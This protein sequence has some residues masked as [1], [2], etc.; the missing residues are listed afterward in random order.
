MGKPTKISRCPRAQSTAALKAAKDSV[1]VKPT[2]V[3][4]RRQHHSKDP[5]EEK[6]QSS[7]VPVIDMK[8]PR[9]LPDKIV[10]AC[11]DWGC[12]RVSNH[13]IPT[14]LLSE[15]KGLA[16]YFLDLPTKI[17]KRNASWKPGQRLQYTLPY[18]VTP[19]FQSLRIDDMIFPG[20]L[21]DFCDRI[22]ASPHQRE[23]LVR[24]PQALYGA[25][26][27]ICEKIMQGYGLLGRG[28]KTSKDW[29]CDLQLNKY[30]FS[31]Q[32][33]GST[34]AIEHSD[35]G[36]FT[37]LQDDELVNGL[38]VMNKF[39]GEWVPVDPIPGTLVVLVG[40]TGMVWSNGRFCNVK[41]RVQCN[42]PM[43]RVSLATFV[44]V[45]RDK[46]VRTPEELIDS[47][48]PRLYKEFFY[49]EDYKH[50]RLSSSPTAEALEHFKVDSTTD[51]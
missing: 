1:S 43:T 46:I 26:I 49:Y 27:E 48:H 35:P 5:M 14:E 15:M 28:E 38:E 12:F 33:L 3:R 18:N 29:V 13:G 23:T 47:K 32:S 30:N 51:D 42:K 40:D 16:R 25:A 39:T 45:T 44:L 34:G 21:D 17:K 37:L 7:S 9:D 22:N 50:L 8:D 20:A 36:F 4:R 24:Y 41:H 10:K 6:T 31:Q 19:Y 11:E 2:T